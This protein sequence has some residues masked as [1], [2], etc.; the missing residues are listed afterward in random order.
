M[1]TA[2]VDNTWAVAVIQ[3]AVAVVAF[4]VDGVHPHDLATVLDLEGVAI[5]AGHHCAEP[6]HRRLGLPASARASLGVY[7][8]DDDVDALLAAIV[9]AQAVLGAAP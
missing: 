5:R 6:L 8:G 2:L 3:A 7:S 9:H 4:A 1:I